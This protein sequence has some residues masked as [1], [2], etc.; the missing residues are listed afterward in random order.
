M[1]QFLHT[2]YLQSHVLCGNRICGNAKNTHL[3]TFALAD[4]RDR[5]AAKVIQ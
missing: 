2:E 1:W 3:Y 4:N 5:C